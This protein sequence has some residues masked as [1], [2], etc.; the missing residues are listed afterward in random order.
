MELKKYR[1]IINIRKQYTSERKI[2]KIDVFIVHHL[3]YIYS[4]SSVIFFNLANHPCE[5][6]VPLFSIIG[7][8]IF[9]NKYDDQIVRIACIHFH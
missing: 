3:Y 5:V 8:N 6:L 4:S 9:L 1:Y 2:I 7:K